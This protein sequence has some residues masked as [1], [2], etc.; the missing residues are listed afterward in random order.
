MCAVSDCCMRIKNLHH[1]KQINEMRTQIIA[2]CTMYQYEINTLRQ[3][4]SLMGVLFVL[5][6]RILSVQAS[7][8]PMPTWETFHL[9]S[10]LS[11][12]SKG[13]LLSEVVSLYLGCTISDCALNKDAS[14]QK[15]ALSI[16]IEG[17][18]WALAS[19]SPHHFFYGWHPRAQANNASRFSFCCSPTHS[20]FHCS[21]GSHPHLGFWKFVYF[22]EA[23]ETVAAEKCTNLEY[24]IFAFIHASTL[25]PLPI[26]CEAIMR[27]LPAIRWKTAW[28]LVCKAP[29]TADKSLWWEIGTEGDGF[30]IFTRGTYVRQHP[31][32]RAVL[33]VACRCGHGCWL[34]SYAL[35]SCWCHCPVPVQGTASQSTV[36]CLLNA[37]SATGCLTCH[38]AFSFWQKWGASL[39]R[40][41]NLSSPCPIPCWPRQWL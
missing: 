25:G 38:L 13:L 15:H 24:N 21:G 16:G 29:N 22:P 31:M 7:L 11:S 32:Q 40:N 12:L 2:V 14:I 4:K 26:C 34:A 19:S 8:S 3:N 5:V 6:H 37:E 18:E 33:S 28:R 17:R 39:Q 1:I 27:P 36:V 41:G 10:T 20:L 35:Q 23:S 30:D 9:F